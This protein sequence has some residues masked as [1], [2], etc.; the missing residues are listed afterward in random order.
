MV[1]DQEHG[2]GHTEDPI[3]LELCATEGQLRPLI[4]NLRTGRDATFDGDKNKK[5]I[6]NKTSPLIWTRPQ[7]TP[8]GLTCA[9]TCQTCLDLECGM[10]HESH[11]RFVLM[12]SIA[13][14]KGNVR[15]LTR[16]EAAHI[17]RLGMTEDEDWI[18]N[19][20]AVAVQF[21]ARLD[22]RTNLP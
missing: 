6:L 11:A 8:A 22:T 10:I 20:F 15:D 17:R 1:A 16:S 21:C 18:R 9:P 13:W 12:P 19:M 2:Q 5:L 7:I 3:F 14:V 4:A